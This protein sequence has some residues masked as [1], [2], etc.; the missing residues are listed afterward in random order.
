MSALAVQPL[1]K[2]SP[3][4]TALIVPSPIRPLAGKGCMPAYSQAVGQV[5]ALRAP[6]SSLVAADHDLRL[7]LIHS[8]KACIKSARNLRVP[9]F[10]SLTAFVE[11]LVGVANVRFRLLHCRH[12]RDAATAGGGGSIQTRR[13]RSETR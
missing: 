5:R 10:T 3:Q 1:L 13:S 7:A 6:G 9:S 12:V 4:G 8:A 11:E 2:S